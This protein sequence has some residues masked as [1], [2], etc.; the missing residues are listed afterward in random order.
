MNLRIN[1]HTYSH[2]NIVFTHLRDHYICVAIDF[3]HLLV[4]SESADRSN[5]TLNATLENVSPRFRM[6]YITCIYEAYFSHLM[7]CEPVVLNSLPN[8]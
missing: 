7:T 2:V 1:I 4:R 6:E 3:F 5:D 8:E